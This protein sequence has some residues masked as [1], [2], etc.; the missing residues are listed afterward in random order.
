M[1]SV[2]LRLAAEGLQCGWEALF[3]EINVHNV[4]AH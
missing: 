3:R 4:K 2:K 1:V